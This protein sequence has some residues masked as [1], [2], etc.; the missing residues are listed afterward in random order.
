MNAMVDAGNSFE[1]TSKSKGEVC[2]DLNTTKSTSPSTNRKIRLCVFN[3]YVLLLTCFRWVD[4][5]RHTEKAHSG[6][7][8]WN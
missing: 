1:A 3:D 2:K 5:P 7:L 8:G 6:V 4:P